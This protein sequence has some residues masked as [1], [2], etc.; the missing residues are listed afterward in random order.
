MILSAAKEQGIDLAQSWLV[1]D[2]LDDVEAGRRA[3]CRTVLI[4]NGNENEWRV[5]KARLPDYIAT[6]MAQAASIIVAAEQGDLPS[7]VHGP[8]RS[9]SGR[10][11]VCR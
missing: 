5:N 7:H 8:W 6:D 1:G 11:G 2:I 3:G 10:Q 9:R 4:D